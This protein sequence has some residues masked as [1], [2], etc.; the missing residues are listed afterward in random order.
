MSNLDGIPFR[1]ISHLRASFLL[2]HAIP[3]M[4]YVFVTILMVI[5]PIG[6]DITRTYIGQ[7]E[8][9]LWS[10]YFWW[11]DY[12]MVSLSTNPLYN[13]YIFYPL[14]LDMMDCIFPLALFIPI[15][16]FFG[17][18]ASYNLYVLSSFI[19]AAYGTY[20]LVKYLLN[21]SYIAFVSGLIFAF[22][23]YHFSAVFGH[24]HTFSIM[25]VPFFVMF[26]LKM[27]DQPT[28]IHVILS[29]VFFALNG[30]T[31]WT[32]A[33]MLSLF[34]L[35]FLI[36][37]YKTLFTKTHLHNL[38]IFGIIS[39]IFMGPGL[40]LMLKNYFSNEHMIVPLSSFIYFSADILGFIIPSPRHPLLGAISNNVYSNFG[41]NYSENIVFMGYS[42]MFLS[43]IGITRLWKNERLRLFAISL[44]VFFVL[45]L[46]P[47]LHINGQWQF[48]ERK[49][50]MI[51]PGVI[52]FY[53]PFVNMIRVPSRFDAM[54]M[55]CLAIIS[56]YGISS[57]FIKNHVK[58][59]GKLLICLAL[60]TIILLEF[61][62]VLPT[63]T[64]KSIP[65]FYYNASQDT[66]YSIIELPI[67]RSTI[68]GTITYGTVGAET[69]NRY[70]EYQK[71][72]HG[73]IFGGY[74][75]RVNPDYEK[76]AESDPV[77]NYLYNGKNDIIKSNPVADK[78]SYL[79]NRYGLNYI[80]LHEALLQPEIKDKIISYL[81]NSYYTDDSVRSDPLIIYSSRNLNTSNKIELEENISLQLASGWYSLENWN[82]MPARW[83]DG[84][85][86][87]EI[88]S[89]KNRTF[90]LN[91]KA[92]SFSRPRTL[93]I[94]TNGKIEGQFSV[95]ST[96]WINLS[97]PIHITE[98][99]NSIELKVPEGCDLPDPNARC[100]SLAI[101]N[102]YLF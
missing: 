21:D 88:N 89:I 9:V 7:N 28:L 75:G 95:P 53:L 55:F 52:T 19:L 34:M 62:A 79:K 57:I 65:D 92:L 60:S 29:S 36:V 81:G 46:G 98:G 50:Y 33:V 56:G 22:C 80:V 5:V 102:I 14:G 96:E 20:L 54:V 101:Q 48:T 84:K 91:L 93:E 16:H 66:N 67:I 76:M 71:I 85:A 3:F 82:G 73:R 97:V 23:P 90:S 40:Y 61:A 64:V 15:T 69:M 4:L 86:G 42:V 59:T 38:M 74:F 27:Y 70:Y 51:L 77:L 18:V 35:V 13:S 31:S 1:I 99:S 47:V 37:N 44:I 87:L 78:L 17:S 32:V 11:F 25:W 6:F 45:A 58:R 41:G 30:L 94:Y 24:V 26:F 12:S 72:H 8:V 68:D 39:S 2:D 10:N 49:L 63:Q 100:L 83:M 43:F